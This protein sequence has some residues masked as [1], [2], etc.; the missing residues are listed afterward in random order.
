MACLH[1]PYAGC[2][3]GGHSVQHLKQHGHSFCRQPIDCAS[4]AHRDSYLYIS[5][6]ADTKTGYLFCSECDDFIYDPKLD[7]M[8]LE[9]IVSADAKQ[10]KFQCA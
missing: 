4:H 3:Q 9:A 7:S 2:W 10:A 8:H 1:C 5:L 6:G